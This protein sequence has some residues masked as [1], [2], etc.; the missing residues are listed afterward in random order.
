MIRIVKLSID[1]EKLDEFFAYFEQ[2]K[3]RVRYFEGN[4]FL[5]IYQ[6]RN[7]PST[8]FTYSIWDSEEYLEN[9]RKSEVFQEIWKVF[10]TYFNGKPEAWS[11]DVLYSLK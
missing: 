3:D 4:N 1:P 9:Y 11:T 2:I 5:E 10:K 7:K 8:V 6:D